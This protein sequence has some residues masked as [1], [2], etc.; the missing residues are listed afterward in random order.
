MP[1]AAARMAF[2]EDLAAWA[3]SS[4]GE[5]SFF[6]APYAKVGSKRI[7]GMFSDDMADSLKYAVESPWVEPAPVSPNHV[8]RWSGIDLGGRAAIPVIECAYVPPNTAYMIDGTARV[9]R[10]L[11]DEELGKC[12]V[13]LTL[14][15]PSYLL[16]VKLPE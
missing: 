4:S 6:G 1:P 14:N 2:S 9:P 12:V 8:K 15:T 11:S 3:P 10:G 16:K 5:Q 13:K 7:D